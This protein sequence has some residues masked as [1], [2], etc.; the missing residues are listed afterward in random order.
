ML[1][2][3]LIENAKAI[4]KH[5]QIQ[6]KKLNNLRMTTLENSSHDPDKVIYNFWTL[7]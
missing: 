2:T 7:S 3:F 4:L 1:V 6:N 5:R